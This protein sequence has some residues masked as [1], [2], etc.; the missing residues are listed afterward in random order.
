MRVIAARDV[1]I[2]IA[3]VSPSEF[4]LIKLA[5]IASAAASATILLITENPN[6]AMDAMM[7]IDAQSTK[8]RISS[9]SKSLNLKRLRSLTNG[10][11]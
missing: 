6:D 1:Q 11:V 3:A 7:S 5:Q 2:D 10:S 8:S 9:T 4:L